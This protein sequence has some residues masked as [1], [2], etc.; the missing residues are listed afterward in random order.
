M[1]N[2]KY[3]KIYFNLTILKMSFGVLNIKVNGQKLDQTYEDN[4]STIVEEVPSFGSI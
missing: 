2:I 4:G 1:I 3:I